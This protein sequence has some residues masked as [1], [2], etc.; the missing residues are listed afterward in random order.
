MKAQRSG[1]SSE[2]TMTSTLSLPV[3][4]RVAGVGAPVGGRR[5]TIGPGGAGAAG[6]AGRVGVVS[7][8]RTFVAD[9]RGSGLVVRA[10]SVFDS[11]GPSGTR[12]LLSAAAP[13]RSAREV[14]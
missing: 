2:Y 3:S 8:G 6:D 12:G 14:P 1:R 9:V 4:V 7:T 11:A 10:G 13:G 5:E